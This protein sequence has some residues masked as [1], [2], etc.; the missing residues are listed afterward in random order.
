MKLNRRSFFGAAVAAPIIGKQTVTDVVM[1]SANFPTPQFIT[2]PAPPTPNEYV[3]T[4]RRIAKGFFSSDEIEE[5]R[6]Y[7]PHIRASRA[8][9]VDALR[10]VSPAMKFIIM[11]DRELEVTKKQRKWSA[12]RQLFAMGKKL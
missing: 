10:S 6:M 2:A 4:T 3:D 8:A 12:L 9:N 1:E 11:A 5:W 7:S